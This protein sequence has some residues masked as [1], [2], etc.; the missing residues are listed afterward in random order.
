M[1]RPVSAEIID[2]L[3]QT[4]RAAV[5]AAN[6]FVLHAESAGYFSEVS[7]S[8]RASCPQIFDCL[9]NF[10]ANLEMRL[11]CLVFAL[12]LVSA[13]FSISLGRAENV[14]GKLF[15]T[16]IIQYFPLWRGQALACMNVIFA[17]SAIQAHIAVIGEHSKVTRSYH[18][19]QSG[20]VI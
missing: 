19:G 16:H 1:K 4:K 11:I 2:P 14:I 17:H 3:A 6:V 7:V 9:A 20:S 12:N 10:A 8:L 5:P 13:Q 15:T 18:P